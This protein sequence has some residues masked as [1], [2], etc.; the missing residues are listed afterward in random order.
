[1]CLSHHLKIS[2]GFE[3]IAAEENTDDMEKILTASYLCQVKTKVDMIKFIGDA[4]SVLHTCRYKYS[5]GRDAIDL[6]IK[7][8]RI[9]KGNR[10]H[11][12]HGCKLGTKYIKADNHISTDHQFLKGVYKIKSGIENTI[13]T[14]K[15]ILS[16]NSKD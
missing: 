14:N 1:M 3:P 9:N 5:Q 2:P 6:I 8:V 12:L 13:T 10:D 4:N 15:K 16:E 11:V 7:Q